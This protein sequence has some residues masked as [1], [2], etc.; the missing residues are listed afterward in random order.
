MV[1]PRVLVLHLWV[2]FYILREPYSIISSRSLSDRSL[3]LL[4][5]RWLASIIYHLQIYVQ[6]VALRLMSRIRTL[7]KSLI[8]LLQVVIRNL[9]IS[10]RLL[11]S[12]LDPTHG[13]C[14]LNHR[15]LSQLSDV[16]AAVHPSNCK[17]QTRV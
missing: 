1:Q 2:F 16:T 8:L 15:K 11:T 9:S 12:F 17:F 13:K 6:M 14:Q 7:S 4:I 10:Q 3:L 5:R